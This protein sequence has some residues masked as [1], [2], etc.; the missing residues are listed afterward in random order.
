VAQ[1]A[2]LPALPS[3]ARGANKPAPYSVVQWAERQVPLSDSLWAV[4]QALSW[5]RA[6]VAQ[7]VPVSAK[8]CTT[9]HRSTVTAARAPAP[10]AMKPATASAAMAITNTNTNITAT[11]GMVVG[12][13]TTD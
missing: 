5:V 8:A 13:L 4:A 12:V 1:L 2:A 3:R 7:R 11:T 6:L 9:A 10:E